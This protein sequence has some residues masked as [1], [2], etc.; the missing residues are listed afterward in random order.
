MSDIPS[1]A[2][3]ILKSESLMNRQTRDDS[4]DSSDGEPFEMESFLKRLEKGQKKIF[5]KMEKNE[6]VYNT[7]M[8]KVEDN[9]SSLSSN[10]TT[11]ITETVTA[12]KCVNIEVQALLDLL[13]SEMDTVKAENISLS[14]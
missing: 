5:K 8:K 13:R 6:T 4:S 12:Q 2:E 10:I 14:Q 1:L 7:R 9:L 3:E 11:Q